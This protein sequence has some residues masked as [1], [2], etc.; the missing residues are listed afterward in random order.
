[1]ELAKRLYKSQRYAES[2]DTYRQE[3]NLDCHNLALMRF[4]LQ[5]L[6]FP[7]PND[8]SLCSSHVG[9]FD[10]AEECALESIRIQPTS[11]VLN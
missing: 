9:E 7:S 6:L 8:F 5:Y 4:I 10:D 2:L 11:K 3:N 1:M